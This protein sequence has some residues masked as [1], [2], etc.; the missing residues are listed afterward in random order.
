M[1]G[2]NYDPHLP[3]VVKEPKVELP[4]FGGH[5]SAWDLPTDLARKEGLTLSKYLRRILR[6]HL[7]AKGR[8]RPGR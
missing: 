8:L 3:E 7:R 1:N 5:V 4:R 6:R 2:V